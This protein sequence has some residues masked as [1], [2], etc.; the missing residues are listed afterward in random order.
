MCYILKWTIFCVIASKM[1]KLFLLSLYVC[2][3]RTFFGV[4][5]QITLEMSAELHVRRPVR[6]VSSFCCI[7][8]WNILNFSTAHRVLKGRLWIDDWEVELDSRLLSS[9]NSASSVVRTKCVGGYTIS[10]VRGGWGVLWSQRPGAGSWSLQWSAEFKNMWGYTSTSH[11]Y[12]VVL[13][14]GHI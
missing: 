4:M 12:G 14:H 9:H 8:G 13:K 5:K 1:R 7:Q 11:A 6:C 2:M 3:F 10:T